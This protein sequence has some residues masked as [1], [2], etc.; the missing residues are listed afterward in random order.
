MKNNVKIYIVCNDPY[1]TKSIIDDIFDESFQVDC[2]VPKYEILS[3]SIDQYTAYYASASVQADK[4]LLSKAKLLKVIA[5][6]STGTDHIDRKFAEN[7]GIQIID[8][9]KEYE[10][11]DTFSATAEMAWCLL[12]SLIRHLPQAFIDAKNGVWS[13][14]K[15]TGIQLL[16]KTIGILGFGRLGK[17][18]AQ[19]ALGF[20]MNVLACDLN[21][22]NE[23][24]VRPV[25]FDTLIKE[26]DFITIHVHLSDQT[27]GMIDDT[28]FSKMK[29]GAFL[30]NTSRGAIINEN[31]L[32]DA[33][34]S[35]KLAGAG[36]DVICGE[37]DQNLDRHPLI[38]YANTHS[39]LIITP[40]IA[41]S[42]T[43]SI[44]DARIFTAKKLA[45]YLK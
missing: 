22:I 32:L 17:M 20:R 25:D 9:A 21:P 23:P 24:G 3:N 42:T 45:N 43:E 5:T 18:M 10:L 37:W 28:A 16:G 44:E 38:Q 35:G 13:R 4:K 30:I 7:N 29:N 40:H 41:G 39:N 36:L 2:I 34:I 33:L 1:L 8:I 27:R 19:N 31:A 12:L 15:H 26:S 14:Q 6:P 11:L